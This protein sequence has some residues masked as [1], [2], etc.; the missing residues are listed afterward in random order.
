MHPKNAAKKAS[1]VQ[2][3]QKCCSMKRKPQTGGGTQGAQPNA[4]QQAKK[5]SVTHDGRQARVGVRRRHRRRRALASDARQL[6]S[7][8]QKAARRAH[9]LEQLGAQPRVLAVHR[10][11][12]RGLRQ[13]QAAL[14]LERRK[15]RRQLLRQAAAA[16]GAAGRAAVPA[17]SSSCGRGPHDDEAVVA[18]LAERMAARRASWRAL[19]AAQPRRVRER[20]VLLV[21]PAAAAGGA[22]LALLEVIC[23]QTHAERAL[24]IKAALG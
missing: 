17:P 3:K 16:A 15:R 8:K 5:S 21:C 7:A 14:R 20:V 22:G 19:A 6:Q 9:A 4:L 13:A 12:A 18:R 11:V 1:A 23:V 10:A 2:R 24:R